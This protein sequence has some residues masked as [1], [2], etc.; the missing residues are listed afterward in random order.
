[1]TSIIDGLAMLNNILET[2]VVTWTNWFF[3]FKMFVK[4]FLRIEHETFIRSSN[5]LLL[6]NVEQVLNASENL[7][8]SFEVNQLSRI[9]E[10]I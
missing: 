7:D 5:N 8:W 2:K 3:H 6:N 4:F 9:R 10:N 1:M